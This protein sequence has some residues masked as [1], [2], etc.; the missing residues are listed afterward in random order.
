MKDYMSTCRGYD[1][2]QCHHG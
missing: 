2:C 1:L